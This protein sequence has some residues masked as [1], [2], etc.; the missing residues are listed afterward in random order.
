MKKLFVTFFCMALACFSLS[1]GGRQQSGGGSPAA[2]TAGTVPQGYAVPVSQGGELTDT[3]TIFAGW[4]VISPDDTIM[5]RYLREKTG[6]NFRVK[7][8]QSN[9]V[10]TSV[11]L[12]LASGEQLADILVLG[13]NMTI[14]NA[15]IDSGKVMELS[16]L[17]NSKTLTTIPNIPQKIKDYVV[18]SNGKIFV[19]P[20][21]YAQDPDD[22]W[23]GWTLDAFWIRT[24]L[25]QQAGV[26]EQDLS[27]LAG[28][29]EALRKFKALRNPAGNPMIPMSFIQNTHQERIILAMFGVD[30]AD[31]VS[32]MPPVMNIGGK[33]VFAFDNPDYLEAFKWMSRLYNEGLIDMEVTTQNA[34]RFQE[35]LE[36]GQFAGYAGNGSQGTWDYWKEMKG[37]EDGPARW[38]M[39]P[40][41]SPKVAGKSKQAVIYINPF[42]SH[43]IFISN[44]TRRLNAVTHYL[45]WAQEPVYY[46][47]HEADNGPVG[48]TWW[49]T[50]DAKMQWQFETGYEQERQ[51]GDATRTARMSPQLYM[52]SPYAKN[53]YPW[54]NMKAD[55]VVAPG[56]L[57]NVKYCNYIGQE[58]VNHRVINNMDMVQA[59][60][61]GVIAQNLP[62]L[63][64]VRDEYTAKMIMAKTQAECETVYREFLRM[65]ETRANW[66]GMKAE[67]ERL[68]GAIR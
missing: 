63:N 9:D 10:Q 4:N 66:S 17:Y 64:Q 6:I 30:M 35:K 65:L 3:F 50:D 59:P 23:P 46:R 62:T 52:V 19:I 48:T 26:T 7:G 41:Q 20:G 11:N 54:F 49:F 45:E 33:Y 28:F 15:L 43:Y 34:E 39:Y 14:R 21:Y 32:G 27:T 25:M 18:E 57:L 2:S 37:P 58:I 38:Y 47:Q 1:A 44:D 55:A 31:G 36:S 61:D 24:D 22:P 42:P 68:Y 51:S 5:Q 29:E 16:S 53:W 60:P 56:N 12:M 13:R 8:I 67:W 40:F